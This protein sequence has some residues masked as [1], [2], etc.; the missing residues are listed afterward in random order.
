MYDLG[1]QY[2]MTHLLVAFYQGDS[3]TAAFDIE[4]SVDG[5]SWVGVFQGGSSGTTLDQEQFNF[6]DTSERYVRIV[7][8]GSS[9]NDWNSI[10]EVDIFG[11][12]DSND[13]LVPPPTPTN[14][15]IIS[16]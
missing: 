4:V 6:A 1:S 2:T 12:L 16:Y 9:A 8:H 3:R 15:T 11:Q 7:G 10:T 13:N 14:V 5:S